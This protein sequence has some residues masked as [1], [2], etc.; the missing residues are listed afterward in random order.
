MHRSD[1]RDKG[2]GFKTV[3]AESLVLVLS[4]VVNPALGGLT[5]GSSG[6]GAGD[7]GLVPRVAATVSLIELPRCR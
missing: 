1:F 7:S 4:L 3:A 5:S 2:Q 6:F